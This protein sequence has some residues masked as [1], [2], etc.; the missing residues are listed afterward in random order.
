MPKRIDVSIEL[1]IVEIK[2]L[3]V[4]KYNP[5]FITDEA[6]NG[7][8]LSLERYGYISLLIVNKRSMEII[9]GH[10]RYKILKA[11]GIDKIP[12]IMVDLPEQTAKLLN[13]TLNNKEISGFWTMKVLP[14][15]NSLKSEKY[16]EYIDL[17][18]EALK[19]E[20][21]ISDHIFEDTIRE[22][23]LD[24]HL[25]TSFKCPRCQYEW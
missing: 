8:Q 15:L 12:V 19:K 22:K 13:V 21:G 6:L 4:A 9:G 24:V 14:L 16:Q 25:P 20:A 11:R 18:L 3:K 10:Q 23:E 7:L 2:Q 5:R 17:Q 1:K